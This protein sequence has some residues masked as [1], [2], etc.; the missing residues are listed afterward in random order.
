MAKTNATATKAAA[1][2]AGI[3][4]TKLSDFIKSMNWLQVIQFI[5]QIIGI[6]SSKP[7]TMK[8]GQGAGGDDLECIRAH[9]DAISDMAECGRKCCGG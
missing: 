4:W 3:D 7:P 5:Q 6:F 8:A 1:E 9:F 2:A